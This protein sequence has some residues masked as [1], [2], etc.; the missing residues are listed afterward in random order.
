MVN[1]AAKEL[2]LI[3]RQ[4][5]H[6]QTKGLTYLMLLLCAQWVTAALWMALPEPV[7]V[8]C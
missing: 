8:M 5:L 2:S 1:M 6:I 4:M 7:P 3:C